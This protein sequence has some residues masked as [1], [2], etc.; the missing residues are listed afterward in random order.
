MFLSM[1]FCLEV[2]GELPND[3]LLF[4]KKVFSRKKCVVR[5]CWMI[6]PKHFW[7]SIGETLT[8]L[9]EKT[10]CESLLGLD[11][12]SFPVLSHNKLQAPVLVVPFRQFLFL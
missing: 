1:I 4:F 11:L 12:V 9:W 6:F 2:H 8:L 7:E 5:N 10:H 3:F